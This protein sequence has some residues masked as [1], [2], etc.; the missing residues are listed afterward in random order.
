MAWKLRP[1]ASRAD[2]AA[3]RGPS[4]GGDPVKVGELMQRSF[5]TVHP[6]ASIEDV[7]PLLARRDPIPVVEHG[8]LIGLLRRGDLDASAADGRGA[9]RRRIRDLI[10]PDIAYCLESTDLDEARTLMREQGV[11]SLP[12]VDARRTLL[13]ILVAA[14]LPASHDADTQDAA[15]AHT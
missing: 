3:R 1:E 14:D 11:T 2:R 10:A 7:A 9:R 6:D 12:V 8:R 15:S 13:G 5:E 4:E